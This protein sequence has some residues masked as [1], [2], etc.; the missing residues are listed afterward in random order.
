MEQFLAEHVS[1]TLEWTHER[2]PVLYEVNV[3][4]PLNITFIESTTVQLVVPYNTV[5]NVSVTATLCGYGHGKT[6]NTQ[7]LSYGELHV[8]QISCTTFNY[9]YL[10]TKAWICYS[11]QYLIH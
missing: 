4:P 8:Q 10:R 1:V 5:H 2:W 7:E 6:S 9:S 3:K 11:T